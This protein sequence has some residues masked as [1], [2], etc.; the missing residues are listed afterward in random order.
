MRGT[1]IADTSGGGA[2]A[3]ARGTATPRPASTVVLLRDGDHGLETLLLRRNR[4][5]AFA[6]GF[7]VFPGGSID[8]TELRAADGDLQ[9]ASRLAAVRETFEETGLRVDAGDL[10]PLSHWTTPLAERKRFATHFFAAPLRGPAVLRVD[11]SEIEEGRWRGV[12]DACAAQEAGRLR[13]L[14]PTYVTLLALRPFT[15]VSAVLARFRRP[16][17]PSV[18]PVVIQDGDAVVTLYPGDAGYGSADPRAKGPRHRARRE[19]GAWEFQCSGLE[20]SGVVPLVSGEG[21]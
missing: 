2:R 11:G 16:P 5:L 13:V 20:G 4:A 8:A 14:P 3:G 15:S 18:T 9:I 19:S 6:G 10:V 12:S 21:T 17:W 1:T 7:W